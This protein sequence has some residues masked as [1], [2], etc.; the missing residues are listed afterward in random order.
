MYV[1][2]KSIVTVFIMDRHRRCAGHIRQQSI[3]I[4][5]MILF[6]LRYS[7]DSPLLRQPASSGTAHW[8]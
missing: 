2:E 3:L 4:M 6:R 1:R 7:W 8:A 5:G